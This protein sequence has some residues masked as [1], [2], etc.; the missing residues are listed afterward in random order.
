MA[1]QNPTG[2]SP[3]Q[4]RSVLRLTEP[5]GHEPPP[6]PSGQQPDKPLP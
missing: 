6:G 5:A 3:G 1:G 4:H 2:L